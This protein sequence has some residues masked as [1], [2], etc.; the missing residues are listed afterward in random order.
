MKHLVP[1]LSKNSFARVS[2]RE[3]V[4]EHL[5]P[6]LPSTTVDAYDNSQ[7]RK[8][9]AAAHNLS[10]KIIGGGIGTAVGYG[11]YRGVTRGKAF[12]AP[13][14]IK[15]LKKPIH[16]EKAKGLLASTITGAGSGVG[17]YIGSKE[18]L[19]RIKNDPQY[20]YRKAE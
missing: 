20:R 4:D 7:Y 5:R 18:S 12:A 8:K 1:L 19:R 13:I 14:A 3:K 17:G 11:I 9:K 16:P 2:K 6:A 10:S 15:G